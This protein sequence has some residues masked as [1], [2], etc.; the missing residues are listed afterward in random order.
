M[1]FIFAQLLDLFE[2]YLSRVWQKKFKVYEFDFRKAF[3]KFTFNKK[4]LYIKI[5][6]DFFYYAFNTIIKLF[7]TIIYIWIITITLIFH[8]HPLVEYPLWSKLATF[9]HK[10]LH[11]LYFIFFF[12]G[13]I[14][15]IFNSC[16][17]RGCARITKF[18]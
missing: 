1:I 4:N 2:V 9:K 3:T 6:Q 14:I 13:E 5:F 7:F 15:F 16:A 17:H 10:I 12:V 11:L 18:L 8:D